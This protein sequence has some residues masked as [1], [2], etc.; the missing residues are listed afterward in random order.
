MKHSP[1]IH[2]KL[3]K[4]DESEMIHQP[5]D[6][7]HL[8]QFGISLLIYITYN[9]LASASLFTSFTSV[10]HQPLYLHHLHQFGIHLFEI[11]LDLRGNE[12]KIDRKNQ[13]H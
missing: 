7:H 13:E 12:E 4:E 2:I 5:L 11:I 8:Q 3:T 1:S 6:L 10:W 9:S